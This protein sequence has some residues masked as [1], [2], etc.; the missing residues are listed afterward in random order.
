M[1]WSI[2]TYPLILLGL[3]RGAFLTFQ[4]LE[5]DSAAQKQQLEYWVVISALLFLF[6]KIDYVLSWFLFSGLVGL[7]KFA[8][9]F[10]VVVSKSKGYGFL[11]KLIEEQ[12]I[13]N[14]EPFIAEWIRK[15][16]GARTSAASTAA[17]FLSLSYR[18]VNRLLIQSVADES[19]YFLAK[20]V[21]KTASDVAKEQAKREKLKAKSRERGAT[22]SDAS[23]RDTKSIF[24]SNATDEQ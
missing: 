4:S 17:M 10:M 7:I 22:K 2:L 14:L 23:D 18:N 16:E 24:E 11:Y 6:P 12:F 9:L 13:G 1:L 20:A 15:S 5:K 3:F 19:L 8:L 21:K